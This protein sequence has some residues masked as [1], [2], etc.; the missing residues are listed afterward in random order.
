[1]KSYSKWSDSK[2]SKG[3]VDDELTAAWARL[4][5]AN[6][7]LD[8]HVGPT[9]FEARFVTPWSFYAFD[10]REKSK[11]GRRSREWTTTAATEVDVVLEMA[12]CLGEISRGNSPRLT[13]CLWVELASQFLQPIGQ[14][15]SDGPGCPVEFGDAEILACALEKLSSGVEDVASG[16]L[17]RLGVLV[18]CAS[19]Q[20]L[21]ER[22][23]PIVVPVQHAIER[24]DRPNKAARI[25]THV[26]RR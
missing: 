19:A 2:A 7:S 3:L 20:M 9:T 16:L 23:L 6:D 4:H 1:L 5:A 8:W 13:R 11:V 24:S 12:R 22:G 10:P 25:E 26:E 14:P 15:T 21:D 17:S 18:M